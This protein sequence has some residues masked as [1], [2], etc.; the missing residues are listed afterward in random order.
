M[1]LILYSADGSNCSQRVE[2]ALRY[3]KIPYKI[4]FENSASIGPYGY[5]PAISIDG[6]VISESVAIL[7]FLEELCPEST[8]LPKDILERAKVREVCEYV[9][10]TIHPA[11]NR[12]ILSFLCPE[13]IESEKKA[14][15]AE[16]IE[17]CLC[18]LKPRLFSD[19]AFAIGKSFSVADIFV[20]VIYQKGLTH[21]TRKD[22]NYADHWAN[23]SKIS[24]HE[25]VV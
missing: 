23:M 25:V 14:L 5:V 7:E 19:S 21:G 8:L 1:E 24:G 16:W 12:S 18:N 13:L 20:A 2:W 15:R 9:N 17:K 10:S 11:Q 4:Q 3:K 22:D 6:V